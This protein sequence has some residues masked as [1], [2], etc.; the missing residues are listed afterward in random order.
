MFIKVLKVKIYI[1]FINLYLKN[2]V[3]KILIKIKVYNYNIIIETV[4]KRI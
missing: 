3:I 1:I 4:I 2:V